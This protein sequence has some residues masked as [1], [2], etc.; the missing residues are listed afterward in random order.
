MKFLFT[1]IGLMVS[2]LLAPIAA[3]ESFTVKG[4]GGN[5]LTATSIASFAN[6]WAMTFVNKDLL[7]VTT[8]LGKL[9]LVSPDGKRIEVAGIPEPL[10][11]G[12]GGLGDVVLHPDFANNAL[13]YL[14]LIEADDDGATRGAF[15]VRGK[16]SISEKPMLT[17][18]ERI[19]TQ[20]PKRRGGGHFSHRIAFG[21]RG[22]PQEGKLFITSGDRQEQKPAQRWDMALG[23]VIRLNDDGSLP[24][25]NPF[26]DKGDLAKSFWTLGHRNPLG[27]AF[28]EK[29]QLW[30]NEMGP[31]HG[32]ELNLIKPGQNY[33]WPIVSNGDNYDGTEIPDHDTRPEFAAPSAYWVPSIAPSGLVIYSG[34]QFPNWNGNAFIG[35]LVSRAL[36]RVE[37]KGAQATEVERFAWGKR[38]R[39]V[40]Q[41]PDGALWVLED[42]FAGRLLRLKSP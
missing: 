17:D 15:V 42:R 6:P 3:A 41:G 34:S 30:I 16:L 35:G 25:D 19:W 39:E 1:T 31:K 5:I 29:G 37:L 12:Q 27:I 26:Q 20:S 21:P 38:I 11:G 33:G 14:S 36:I 18:V 9:W 24:V 7:L 10:V 2:A 40:E 22:S 32:D 23:K 4:T 8:R 28:D 13:I